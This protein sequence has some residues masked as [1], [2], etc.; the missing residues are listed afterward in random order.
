[1]HV[2]GHDHAEVDE[3][4]RMRAA[5]RELLEAHHWGHAAPAGFRQT[6]PDDNVSGHDGDGDDGE[7]DAR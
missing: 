6:H 7:V 4:A 3:T 2:L 5:E 1:L